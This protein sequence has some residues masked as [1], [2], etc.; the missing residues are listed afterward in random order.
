MALL[1]A[2]LLASA[3]PGDRELIW[4]DEFDGSTLDLSQWSVVEDCWGG[5][6]RERQCY[7]GANLAV[8]D[9]LLRITARHEPA[10]GARFPAGHPRAGETAR[11]AWTSG[12]IQTRGKA[13][14][15]YGR[16]EVRARLPR[17][18]GVWPAIW[19]LPE[20]DNY[21]PYPQSGEIDIAEAVN[22]GVPCQGCEDRIHGAL[23]HGPS[24]E[25]NRQTTGHARLDTPGGFHTFALEWTPERLTWLLDDVAYFTAEGGPP[26]DQRFHL[27]VNLAVG[28]SWSENSGARGVDPSAFPADLAVDYVRVYRRAGP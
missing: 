16:I 23:H 27:I 4:A 15:L 12:K 26:W 5:G 6:N 21:G 7:T 19:M 17:G 25:A 2:G 14:F 20:H 10:S 11:R 18:Q 1:A 13:S 24:P 9:G 3:D 8:S 28:G 22:L